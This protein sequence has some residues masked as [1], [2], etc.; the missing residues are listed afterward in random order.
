MPTVGEYVRGVLLAA[1]GVLL[2][3]LGWKASIPVLSWILIF[4]GGFVALV[5]VGTTAAVAWQ[6]WRERSSREP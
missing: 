5:A 3:F 2:A 4:V 6:A 1:F